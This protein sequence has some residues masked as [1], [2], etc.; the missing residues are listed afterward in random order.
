MRY[1][2]SA[3]RYLLWAVGQLLRRLRRPPDYVVFILEGSYPEL[4]APRAGFLRKRLFPDRLSL[5]E[6]GEQFQAV[7]LDPRVA[8]VITR[9]CPD[10]TD[11]SN[12]VTLWDGSNYKR[13][14]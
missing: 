14:A 7:Q 9:D 12:H 10:Q 2:I 13:A 4:R 6:L 5:Q 3:L 11:S 8:G 1:V